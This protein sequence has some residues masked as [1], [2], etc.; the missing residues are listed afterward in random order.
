MCVCVCACR[1]CRFQ[2]CLPYLTR[3]MYM[4]GIPSTPIAISGP[5]HGIVGLRV[6]DDVIRKI[7]PGRQMLLARNMESD[8]RASGLLQRVAGLDEGG[9]HY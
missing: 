5:V 7:I 6:H 8:I 1:C 9:D 3:L 4:H 2:S